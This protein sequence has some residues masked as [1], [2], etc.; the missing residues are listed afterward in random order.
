MF[1]LK[2]SEPTENRLVLN[3]KVIQ[4]FNTTAELENSQTRIRGKNSKSALVQLI[5]FLGEKY[6]NPDFLIFD[7]GRWV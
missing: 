6:Y 4:C 5:S 1:I 7:T 3:Y 2:S